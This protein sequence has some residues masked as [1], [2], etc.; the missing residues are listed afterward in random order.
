MSA[1]IAKSDGNQPSPRIRRGDRQT[2]FLA[3][4][5]IL[6]EAGSSGLIRAAMLTICLVIAAF[7]VWAW[8]TEVEEVA[9]ASG[10]VVPTGQVQ[11]LQHLEGG[12]IAEI[13][14]K[15]GDMVE[16]GQTLLRM[17][18]AATFAELDQ[19]RARQAS[20]MLKAERL[21]SVG[22]G[23]E[24]DF[25]IVGPQYAAMVRDQKSILASQLAAR[26]N[27]RQILLKQIE[28]RKEDLALLSGQE[29]TTKANLSLLSEELK[30]R[31]TLFK[32]GLS[33][34]IVFLNIK[35]D[36]NQTRG[37][38]NKIIGQRRQTTQALSEAGSRLAELDTDLKETSLA[39]MGAVT[40]ELAQLHEAVNKIEDRVQRLAM[41][42]PVRGIVKGLKTHTVGGVIPPGGVIL[43][44]VPLD[45]ELIVEARITT[46]DVG[47]LREGQ[48]VTV[49]V[50]T[51]DYARYGGITGELKKISASTFL[52]EQGN[53]YYKGIVSLDRGYVGGD[54]ERNRVLPGMTVQA[55]I[56][57]GK[58]TLLQY[59]LKPV[60]SSVNQAFRER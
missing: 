17:D 15:E 18:P 14:V 52:D 42:S 46:R 27:R 38:L 23:R 1:D 24:P 36:V 41:K 30:M 37:D 55:D 54:P 49:K 50:M 31:E 51:Y 21:R 20:L 25:S 26:E 40:S 35:R 11:T 19:M 8:V 6:E 53:P 60:Y 22:E 4:S 59:L 9:A 58:K 10:E 32:K 33:S 48:P 7:I 34:K 29:R 13:L 45:K 2:R 12:I 43:E 57:T 56:N 3:Q 39:E 28:Q 16:A 47:H 5:V 44:L